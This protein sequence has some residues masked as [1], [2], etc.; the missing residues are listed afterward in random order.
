MHSFPNDYALSFQ[1]HLFSAFSLLTFT[2]ESILFFV[3]LDR[4]LLSLPLIFSSYTLIMN[5][6]CL[7]MCSKSEVMERSKRWKIKSIAYRIKI[8]QINT[9]PNGQKLDMK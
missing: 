5:I 7:N 1:T 3:I 6:L 4:S 8:S 9:Y 2:P